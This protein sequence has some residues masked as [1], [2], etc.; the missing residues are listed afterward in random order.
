MIFLGCWC[1]HGMRGE[2]DAKCE[3]HA[4][5]CVKGGWSALQWWLP[6]ERGARKI[7]R[8][9]Q[10]GEEIFISHRRSKNGE[11]RREVRRSWWRGGRCGGRWGG[12]RHAAVS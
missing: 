1:R 6:E 2:R 3:G 7:R 4:E 12:R 5:E 10:L 11:E 9:K 8:R